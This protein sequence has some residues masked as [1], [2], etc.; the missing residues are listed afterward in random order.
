MYIIVL[1]FGFPKVPPPES[2]KSLARSS[3]DDLADC[4]SATSAPRPISS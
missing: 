2:G 4:A 1:D 3:I